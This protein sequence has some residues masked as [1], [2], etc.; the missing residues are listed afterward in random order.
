[1]FLY[2]F[3]KNGST[4]VFFFMLVFVP[5]VWFYDYVENL[6][7]IYIDSFLPV[8]THAPKPIGYFVFFKHYKNNNIL[9]QMFSGPLI[10]DFHH[11]TIIH[12]NN[13]IIPDCKY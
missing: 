2:L 13:L 3:S 6:L 7:V 9:M 8:W 11:N 1:M 12:N 4:R 10:Q 5:L